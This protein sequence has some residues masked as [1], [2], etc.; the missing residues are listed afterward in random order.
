MGDGQ[1]SPEASVARAI[2]NESFRPKWKIFNFKQ[3]IQVSFKPGVSGL[4]SRQQEI[5]KLEM[6]RGLRI[7]ETCR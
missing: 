7:L 4:R 5:P 3:K 6:A 2:S 1:A